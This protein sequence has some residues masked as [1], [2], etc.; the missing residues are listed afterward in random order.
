MSAKPIDKLEAGMEAL[1]E[2]LFTR[3]LQPTTGMRDLAIL[4]LRAM[5][6][7]ANAATDEDQR[8]IAPDRFIL[9]L[10]P[11]DVGRLQA[12]SPDYLQRFQ[13][14]LGALASEAGYRLLRSPSIDIRPSEA[15]YDQTPRAYAEHSLSALGDTKVAPAVAAGM[16]SEVR[17]APILVLDDEREI[18]LE[19]LLITVGREADNDIIVDDAY[20]SRYHLE[21]RKEFGRYTLVDVG[22]RGGTSVNNSIVREHILQ[23]GDR[24][25]IGHTCMTFV[26]RAAPAFGDGTTQVLDPD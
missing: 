5:A 13:D 8:P 20:A 22:S 14:L 21:L 26:D 6:D 4:L 15:T 12:L 10:D 25:E 7:E 23:A 18:A 19:E 16:S 1:I 11:D 9:I 3:L 2:G 17:P 24:I